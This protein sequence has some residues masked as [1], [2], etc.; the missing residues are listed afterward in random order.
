[1][2]KRFIAVALLAATVS[3]SALGGCV[4][5]AKGIASIEKTGTAGLVDTYTITYT[6]GTTSTFTVTNGKDGEDASKITVDDVYEFYK[7]TDPDITKEEFVNKFLTVENGGTSQDNLNALSSLFRSGL[8]VYTVFKESKYNAALGKFVATDAS[9]TGSAVIYKIDDDYT[10]LLTNYHVVYDAKDV[11]TDKICYKA[12]AYMYGSEYKPYA[13]EDGEVV[14]ADD[15]ALS[16]EYV[17]GSAACD[18]GILKV[19][20]ATLKAVYPYAQAVTVNQSYE[21]GQTVYALGNLGNAGLSLTKGVVSVD[22]EMVTIN[23]DYD[24]MYYLLRTD[25]DLDHGSSGGGLFN[26]DGEYIALCNSGREDI[27]SINNA[28]PASTVVPCV[29]GI[30]HYNG[31]DANE[32]AT[33]R[34]LLGVTVNEAN[35]RYVYDTK[36][37]SGSIVAD[38]TVSE[39]LD[40]E[41]NPIAGKIA[42]K[43]GLKVGD[44]IRAISINGVKYEV[45]RM[46]RMSEVLMRVREG[47]GVT[48]TYERNNEQKESAAYTV[49]KSD[50]TAA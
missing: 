13:N 32:H 14:A 10:Y 15:F 17:G 46:F 42:D 43:L 29:E 24:R 9:Y 40:G 20:T 28:V 39:P 48:I 38:I 33:Y 49:L 21:V 26:A 12:F 3:L 18:V 34:L 25:A 22:V 45:T 19:P 47:D 6:D 16:C 36:K 5:N 50:L 1:M 2:K 31:L 35:C 41:Q 37:G 27:Q 44:I 30:L 23:I 4:V 7:Q 11:G 8:K